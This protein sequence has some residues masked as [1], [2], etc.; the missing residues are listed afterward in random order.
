MICVKAPAFSEA[1]ISEGAEELTLRADEVGTQPSATR[2]TLNSRGGGRRWLM[3]TG[4]PSAKQSTQDLKGK[5]EKIC[6]VTAEK[7]KVK[8]Q[9]AKALQAMK[10]AWYRCEGYDPARKED[11]LVR[12]RSRLYLWEEHH[13]SLVATRDDCNGVQH[14]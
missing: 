12:T 14:G 4:M 13:S 1:T 2:S 10:V 11:I 7:Q 8:N 3:R 9:K 5:N 6:I